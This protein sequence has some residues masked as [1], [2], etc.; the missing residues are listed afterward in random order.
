MKKLYLLLFIL[1]FVPV[2]LIS[3]EIKVSYPNFRNNIIKLNLIPISALINGHNQKWVGIEYERFL[4]QN[5]S[6]SLAADVGLF[7]D[8]SFIKYHDYFNE[9]DG[10][11]YTQINS[12]T[13]GYHLKP[14]IKYY[15]LTTKSKKGQGF[16]LGGMLDFNQYFNNTEIFKSRPNSTNQYGLTTGRLCAGTLLGAQYVAFSRISIDLN[17]SIVACLITINSSDD[18]KEIDPLNAIWVFNGNT[19]W[20]TVNLMIGYAFGGGKRR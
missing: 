3:Q 2:C 9:H 4:K 19:G 14:S 8:Y 15:F 5:L 11:S 20:S 16:Y 13:W 1:F 7:E 18:F 10:F 6:V 12:Q 17:I